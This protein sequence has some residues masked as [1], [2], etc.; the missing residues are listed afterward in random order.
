M[1]LSIIAKVG[2]GLGLTWERGGC[3]YINEVY[4]KGEGVPLK[5]I[6]ITGPGILGS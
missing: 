3:L 2:L 4:S 1:L 5:E 6:I